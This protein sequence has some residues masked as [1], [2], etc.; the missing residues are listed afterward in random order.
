MLG[1]RGHFSTKSRRYST[2]L[3]ALRTAR[4]QWRTAEMLR[5]HGI[6]AEDASNVVIAGH[7]AYSG[8]GY[9][10]GEAVFAKT[11]AED[12][13]EARHLSRPR[14]PEEWEQPE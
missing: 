13:T 4:R 6:T 8:R 9:S 10:E 11:V 3:G 5:A 2:T 14:L 7:W 1:F 12:A